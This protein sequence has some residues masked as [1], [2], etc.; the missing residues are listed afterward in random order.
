[1]V[2]SIT[3]D[4]WRLRF[5]APSITG[6]NVD[7]VAQPLKFSIEK[8]INFLVILLALLYSEMNCNSELLTYA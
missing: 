1:M 4:D 3:S 2:A 6:L 8:L 7:D 5:G